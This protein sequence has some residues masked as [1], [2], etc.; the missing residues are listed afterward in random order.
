[1]ISKTIEAAIN[2]QIAK[3]MYS[4]N[5]YLSMASYFYTNNFNGFANWMRAQAEEETYHAMRFL[6]YLVSRGGDLKIFQI[7]EPKL[8]WNSPLEVFQAALEHERYVTASIHSLA[9]LSAKEKDYAT[10]IMLQWFITEQ[11]EK[12]A[13]VEDIVNKLEMVSDFKGAILMLDNELKSRT[14]TPPTSE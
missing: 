7:D 13:S 8:T 6:D 14:F 9:D 10:S 11:V 1:M 12:E 4:S 5:L 2:E 3:E